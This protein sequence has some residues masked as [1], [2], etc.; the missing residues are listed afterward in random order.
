MKASQ[1]L[2]ELSK[3]NPEEL[4]KIKGIGE[5]L[6]ENFQAFFTSKRYQNIQEKLQKLESQN[7]QIIINLT[8]KNQ[9]Q[10]QSKNAIL[11]NKSICI[12]GTFDQSRLE[13]KKQL[14][15][16]GAKITETVT[17]KTDFLLCGQNPGSKKA[18]A[19]KLNI[20]IFSSANDLLKLQT[21]NP[22]I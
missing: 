22:Q 20:R 18:K 7:N 16:L 9:S 10:N 6:V 19:E 8:A 13:I 21:K 4:L 2:S 15:N 3:I 12:T 11:F 5:V 17:S 1:F 14:E